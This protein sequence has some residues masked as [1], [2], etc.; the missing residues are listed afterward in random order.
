MG[1]FQ[2]STISL[3]PSMFWISVSTGSR[4]PRR[5]TGHG[6]PGWGREK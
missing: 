5:L 2:T 1:H 6:P 4:P 3:R